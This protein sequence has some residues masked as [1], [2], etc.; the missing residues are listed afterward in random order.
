MRRST[1]QNDAGDAPHIGSAFGTNIAPGTTRVSR[2][3]TANGT[4]VATTHGTNLA[5][6]AGHA[7][8]VEPVSETSGTAHDTGIT[9]PEIS[10]APGTVIALGRTTNN[11]PGNGIVNVAGDVSGTRTTPETGNIPEVII[12]SSIGGESGAGTALAVGVTHNTG[13]AHET[14]G[15]YNSSETGTAQD[16]RTANGIGNGQGCSTPPEARQASDQLSTEAKRDP[17]AIESK[18]KACD[19]EAVE[20]RVA[21][22]C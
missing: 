11:L 18:E 19:E 15:I 2:T 1:T 10:S 9:H 13:N 12:S 8:G 7:P 3:G 14:H 5:R 17:D 22:P 21:L 16:A 20:E 4:G 6:S